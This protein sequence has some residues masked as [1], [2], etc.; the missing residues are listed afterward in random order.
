MR[1]YE[2]TDDQWAS[3]EHLFPTRAGG[4]GRPAKSH[5]LM[6]NGILWVLFSGASWRDVPDRFG[7]WKTVYD[8]FRSWTKDGTFKR[9]LEH[10][11]WETDNRGLLDWTLFSVDSTI[12]RA[13][14]AAAGAKKKPPV[15]PSQT[16]H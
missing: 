10:L 8:R 13:S 5:R 7:S 3:I 16:R 15:K 9:I 4:R 12:V 1:R 11:Q 14:K 6:L 2:L